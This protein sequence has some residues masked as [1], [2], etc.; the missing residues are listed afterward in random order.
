MAEP[1][2]ASGISITALFIALLGPLAGQYTAI[3]LGMDT[4]QRVTP[5]RILHAI[6]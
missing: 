4:R 3:V 1:T 6:R 5:E 2:T